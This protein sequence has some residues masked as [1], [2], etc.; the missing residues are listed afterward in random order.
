MLKMRENSMRDHTG[1][2]ATDHEGILGAMRAQLKGVEQSLPLACHVAFGLLMLNGGRTGA[3]GPLAIATSCARSR[4]SVMAQISTADHD[5]QRTE[6]MRALSVVKKDTPLMR[7][8]SKAGR[9]RGV[10]RCMSGQIKVD[11]R[12]VCRDSASRRWKHAQKGFPRANV[13]M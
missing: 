11:P 5:N 6:A 9:Y 12:V 13:S 10:A 8:R 3:G 4:I 7:R 1:T 2:N